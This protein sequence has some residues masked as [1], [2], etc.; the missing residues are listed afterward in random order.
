M[1]RERLRGLMVVRKG[2]RGR[3]TGLCVEG[4]EHAS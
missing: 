1:K 2:R 3:Q 4:E